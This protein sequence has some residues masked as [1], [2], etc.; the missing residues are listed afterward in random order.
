MFAAFLDLKKAF[1]SIDRQKLLDKLSRLGVSDQFLR[2]LTRLYTKDVFSLLLDGEPSSQKF[3][4]AAGVHEGSPLS[5]L[6]F[7]LYVSDL[8][9]FLNRNGASQGGVQ[10]EDGT[11]IYCI[12]YAD[13]VL[14]LA[15]T[16]DGLQ[17][18][19]DST[20]QYFINEGMQVNP[21]KS[22]ILVFSNS[23]LPHTARF[24]VAGED[25][26]PVSDTK[27][28]GVLFERTATWKKQKG[29]AAVKS[30][31]ALGRSKMI[32][33]SLNLTNL[34]TLIQIF[35]M[36]VSSVFRYSAG[37]WGP[38]A[39]NMEVID[40]IFCDFVK[41]RYKLPV[42]TSHSGI[43]TQFGRRCASC[44][45]FYLAAVH[46]ARGRLEPSSTWGR[47]LHSALACQQNKWI[48]EV[49]ERLNAMSMWAEVMNTPSDFLENRKTIAVNFA[50]WCHHNHL[51]FANGTSADMM[52][53]ARP[54]GI[55]PAVYD[56]PV[57]HARKILLLLLSVWRWGLEGADMYPE[58]CVECDCLNSSHHLLFRCVRMNNIR[59]AF[60]R[61]TGCDFS[62]E[63]VYESGL[64]Q[65]LMRV[66]AGIC[67]VV[68]SYHG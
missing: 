54:Y 12:L 65:P 19:I 51:K 48:A 59:H 64:T 17:K 18:L 32:C 30:R 34:R 4:V 49:R 2:V 39:G 14:L 24:R 33:S 8:I 68:Q 47:V 7:I 11:V 23:R 13:D 28:L 62:E 21:I 60:K 10:L 58:Y 20:T 43:L 46:V 67:Q 1:P 15:T 9:A 53:V 6:L 55:L 61:E 56:T 40:K 37:A 42:T 52:R 22:E 66:F 57:T 31:V 36:F 3:N 44:D 29:A 35:D 27:Y 63:I 50:Q 16:Q 41:S 26:A 38:T 45:A 5:P 25:K